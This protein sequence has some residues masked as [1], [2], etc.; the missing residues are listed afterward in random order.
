[1]TT[2]YVKTLITDEASD[3]DSP[4]TE[5][6]M[7]DIIQSINYLIDVTTATGGNSETLDLSNI[8]LT[9]LSH[10]ESSWTSIANG[11]GQAFAHGLGRTPFFVMI[12]QANTAAFDDAAIYGSEANLN[13]SIDHINVVD[14]TN[15]NIVNR[16]GSTQFFKVF[17]F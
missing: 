7:Q 10:Y 17:A 2:T 11:N 16:V 1:M 4:G 14:G 13:S 15:V 9:D 8:L 12:Y 6:F 3:E 5:T